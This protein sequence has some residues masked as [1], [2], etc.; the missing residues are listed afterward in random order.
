[1]T[2]PAPTTVPTAD[3]PPAAPLPSQV[4]PDLLAMWQR[5]QARLAQMQQDVLRAE[6]GVM[7]TEAEIRERCQLGPQ[8]H[9]LETGAIVRGAPPLP[10]APPP[11]PQEPV[12]EAPA[13]VPPPADP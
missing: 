10:G 3:A 11:A 9:I 13:L 5:A 12:R 8:D 4:P 6:G 2:S 7:L 1:M